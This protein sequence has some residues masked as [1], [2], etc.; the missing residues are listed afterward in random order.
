M[1]ATYFKLITILLIMV[2]SNRVYSQSKIDCSKATTQTEINTCSQNEYIAADKELNDIYRKVIGK[3]NTQQ[4]FSLIQ[5]QKKW[6][7]FRDDYSKI[8]DLVY[9][10]GS[11]ATSAVVRCKTDVTRARIT[12]LKTLFDQISL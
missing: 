4:K 7:V 8:Y 12:E 11:M 6:I 3:L 9:K 1:K 10:G 5:S 2:C